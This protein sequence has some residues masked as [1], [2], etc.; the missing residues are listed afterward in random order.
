MLR[1]K[2]TP[3]KRGLLFGF[4]DWFSSLIAEI[5]HKKGADLNASSP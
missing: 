2:K 1:C 4:H 3:E 5:I